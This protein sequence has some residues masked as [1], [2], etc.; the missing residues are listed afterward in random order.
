MRSSVKHVAAVLAAGAMLAPGVALARDPEQVA[1]IALAPM[2]YQEQL[3]QFL[4][5]GSTMLTVHFVDADHLL[6][7]FGLR[8]LMKREPNDPPDDDDRMVGANLVEL[9]SGKVLAQTQWRMHDRGQ[10]LWNLGQ[11]RFLLRVRDQL[12]V[13]APMQGVGKGDA[14]HERPLLHFDHNLVAL[15]VSADGD[16]LTVETNF[17]TPGNAGVATD[18]TVVDP[19][20]AAPAPIQITFYRIL[21]TGDGMESLVLSSAGTIGARAPVD[22]P[23]TTAGF[24][25]AIDGGKNRWLFN[26]D[27]HT[28]KVHELAEW[29]TSC[30]PHSTFI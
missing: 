29:D 17:R 11:G 15:Q 6:I 25:D 9:P 1:H 8:Q 24:L 10:Y 2:G 26:F 28:G 22:I 23:L 14:F 20:H 21:T 4:L 30:F 27:E 16:L 18:V 5:G 12:S 13:I 19:G 3:P 7:T